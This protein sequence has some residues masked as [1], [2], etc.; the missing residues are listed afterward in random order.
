VSGWD[1]RG[2]GPGEDW[3]PPTDAGVRAGRWNPRDRAAQEGPS[4]PGGSLPL[5]RDG[6]DGDLYA[7]GP[8]NG[9]AA[10][11]GPS[12]GGPSAGYA[13]NGNS[14]ARGTLP[15]PWDPP[16][17]AWPDA[18][19][20]PGPDWHNNGSAP[21]RGYT[22]NGLLPPV[23]PHDRRS[24]GGGLTRALTAVLLIVG[25]AALITAIGVTLIAPAVTGA[26]RDLARS[27][28]SM[29][30]FGPVA[31]I[32]KSDLGSALNEPAGTDTTAVRFRVADGVAA[33]DVARA[34]EDAGLVRD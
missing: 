30:R 11:Q 26:I 10:N 23:S 20:D 14:R 1:D 12:A 6:Y 27:N 17:G 16:A 33:S 22:P 34:L 19:G 13:S 25:V 7:G 9:Y 29:M 4:S 21:G 32:V 31:D 2:P 18:N 3:P 24:A 5:P 28:P 8:Y 15:Q